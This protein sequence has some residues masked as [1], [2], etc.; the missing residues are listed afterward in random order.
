MATREELHNSFRTAFVLRAIPFLREVHNKCKNGYNSIDVKIT[1][2]KHEVSSLTVPTMLDLGIL[3]CTGAKKTAMFHWKSGLE[4]SEKLAMS[5]YDKMTSNI[6]AV[7]AKKKMDEQ[8]TQNLKNKKLIPIVGSKRPREFSQ[9]T[10]LILRSMDAVYE[11]TKNGGLLARFMILDIIKKEITNDTISERIMKAFIDGNYIVSKL[12]LSA[13]PDN[14]MY[15]WKEQAPNEEHASFINDMIQENNGNDRSNRI[16]DLLMF[17]YNLKDYTKL[18]M[19]KKIREFR[20]GS[21][22]Q[23]V[24]TSEVLLYE[25]NK[26]SRRYKWKLSEVPSMA[27][28][29]AIERKCTEY[30]AKYKKGEKKETPVLIK[31]TIKIKTTRTVES[32]KSDFL[33]NLMSAVDSM[34]SRR[35]N[36]AAELNELDA[37]IE[38]GKGLISLKEK[39]QSFLSSCSKFIYSKNQLAN[40]EQAMVNSQKE[41]KGYVRH[42]HDKAT[43]IS[44]LNKKETITLNELVEHFYPGKNLTWKNNEVQSLT[45]MIYSLK[46]SNTIESP[47]VGVYKLLKNHA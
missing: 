24:I 45:A 27:L 11:S 35:K 20:M 23:S 46:K 30:A 29:N 43:I 34:E 16:F 44:L 7:K 36:L 26:I 9:M 40:T 21:N 41:P 32:P 13:S 2:K 15:T 18:N 33:T 38:E 12:V 19:R 37:K 4:V 25:G 5:I 22:E 8:R 17:L 6:K 1:S 10:D 14:S 3:T 31:P 47:K 39:E 28:A 42:K